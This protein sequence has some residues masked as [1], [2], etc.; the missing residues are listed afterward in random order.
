[1]MR[2]D[3]TPVID[4][5][6][7]ADVDVD[8][9]SGVINV[10]AAPSGTALARP[11]AKAGAGLALINRTLAEF[12]APLQ[13]L[14]QCQIEME[15]RDY[16]RM[17]PRYAEVLA[18]QATLNA[19]TCDGL[20]A[21]PVPKAMA[22]R[23]LSILFGA[24]AKRKPDDG[25]AAALLLAC[26]DIFDPMGEAI[27][28]IT[29]FWDSVPNHPLVLAL[30]IKRLLATQK[31]A[32]APS[33]VRAAMADIGASLRMRTAFWLEPWLQ[34]V[35]ERDR[36]L[37]EQDR[38][39]WQQIYARVDSSVPAAMRDTGCIGESPDDYDDD[40][41]LPPPSTARWLALDALVEAK[42]AAEAAAAAPLAPET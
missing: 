7:I 29:G 8:A 11:S 16:R 30:A 4:A 23:M 18:A 41:A 42:R 9:G 37:F 3:G 33:E 1:M 31:F 12:A 13:A 38:A 15:G 32:P 24:L 27:G 40:P 25:N 34:A 10:I 14:A 21:A 35:A 22:L 19:I 26:A 36:L 20:H 5:P 6:D 2:G 39:T 17:L 28:E